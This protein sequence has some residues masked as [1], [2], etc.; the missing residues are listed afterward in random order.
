MIPEPVQVPVADN[1]KRRYNVTVPKQV[2][3]CSRLPESTVHCFLASLGRRWLFESKRDG[4]YHLGIA[5]F[6][7]GLAALGQLDVRRVSL[8]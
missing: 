4:V 1:L 3:A 7:I 2:F 8:P 6:A 5:C